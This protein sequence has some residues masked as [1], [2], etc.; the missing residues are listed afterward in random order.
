[1]H[2]VPP[3]PSQ[4]TTSIILNGKPAVYY[5]DTTVYRDRL[6]EI[7][8]NHITIIDFQNFRQYVISGEACSWAQ[9]P[10]KIK[11][12][13]VFPTYDFN[14]NLTHNN[15]LCNKWSGCHDYEIPPAPFYYYATVK[16]NIPVDLNLPTI[17]VNIHFS[18]FTYGPPPSSV[19]DIPNFIIISTDD[20]LIF[21]KDERK[22]S[23][24]NTTFHGTPPS[25]LK[26]SLIIPLEQQSE[27]S[28]RRLTAKYKRGP[29]SKVNPSNTNENNDYGGETT[30][31]VVEQ[32]KFLYKA[33]VTHKVPFQEQVQLVT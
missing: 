24:F 12:M 8:Q 11:P 19:F 27:S 6:D 22:R 26:S 17:D 18:N 30:P 20:I 9:I 33:S 10:G 29:Q 7:N 23:Q 21:S 2:P 25:P 4:Y 1:P 14:G 31:E 15:T 28:L 32:P 13:L 16:G 5:A 3:Q